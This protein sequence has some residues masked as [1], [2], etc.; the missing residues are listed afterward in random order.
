[1]PRSARHTGSR[2]ATLLLLTV[3]PL[4][5]QQPAAESGYDLW[6]RYVGVEDAAL[7]RAYASRITHVVVQGTSP[8]LRA[9]RGELERG[10]RGLLG[11]AVPVGADVTGP[12]ALVVG[13]PA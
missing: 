7:R 11:V 3:A 1:M 2:L 6:L 12:G 8:S 9:A 13:T 5:A 10:L 4:R